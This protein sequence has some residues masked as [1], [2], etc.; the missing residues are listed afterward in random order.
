MKAGLAALRNRRARDL[1]L[2][3]RHREQHIAEDR[4][5]ETVVV[6]PKPS[7]KA[8]LASTAPKAATLYDG[9]TGY[10]DTL[11]GN[12]VSES[13]KWRARQIVDSV[14]KSVRSDCRLAEIDF[15]WLDRLTDHFRARPFVAKYTALSAHFLRLA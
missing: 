6:S 13:H 10:L 15:L 3:N 14:L 5:I 2:L 1:E 8:K 7:T 9:I 4:F 12:R 11:D